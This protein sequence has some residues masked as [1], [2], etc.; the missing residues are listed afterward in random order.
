MR[1][2][3]LSC[4][5]ERERGLAINNKQ[6]RRYCTSK[7]FTKPILHQITGEVL[8]YMSPCFQRFV[9]ELHTEQLKILVLKQVTTNG[10]PTTG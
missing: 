6:T 4:Q 8:E 10:L 5:R 2:D 1:Y 3:C 9:T 7:V